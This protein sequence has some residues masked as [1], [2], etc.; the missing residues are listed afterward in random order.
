MSTRDRGGRKK[1]KLI[2]INTPSEPAIVLGIAHPSQDQSRNYAAG[3]IPVPAGERPANIDVPLPVREQTILSYRVSPAVR[4][5][6]NGFGRFPAPYQPG[7]ATQ[8]ADVMIGHDHMT[9]ATTT[10]PRND[11]LDSR[12]DGAMEL[13][14]SSSQA[15]VDTSTT[16]N[17][18]TGRKLR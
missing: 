10:I 2:K 16:S 11:P 12:P 6:L 3:E 5:V 15:V 4:Q 8:S 1:V 13:R 14:L 9:S 18:I 17:P 7:A